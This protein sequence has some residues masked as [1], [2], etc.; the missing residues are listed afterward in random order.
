MNG[1]TFKGPGEKDVE[2]LGIPNSMHSGSSPKS[3]DSALVKTK[4]GGAGAAGKKTLEDRA[5][6]ANEQALKEDAPTAEMIRANT[7]GPE[8]TSVKPKATLKKV[9][10]TAAKTYF[11]SEAEVCAEFDIP[12][13][14]K[15]KTLVEF[16]LFRKEK[17]ENKPIKK[18]QSHADVSGRVTALLPVTASE[19]PKVT[20]VIKVKHC[21]GEWSSGQGTEREVSETAEIS[22][23]HTQVSGIH[24]SKGKSFIADIY[25]DALCE[26]KKI[27]LEWKKTHEK[28]QIVVYGHTE[29]DEQ[30]APLK[31]SRNRGLAA[32]SFIIGDVDRWADLAEKERWG[33]WEQQCMLRA[34]GFF[35]TK[36]TG[37]LG[38]ITRKAVQDFI[39][40]LNEARCKNINPML[41]L[42]EAYIRKEL[43]REYLNLKRSE[44]ELPSSAFRLVAG[45][46]YVGCCA[47][48]R[49]Q[50]RETLHEENRRVV[51]LIL[52]ESPNFPATFPC[53]SSTAGPCEQESQK[54]GDRAIKGFKCKFYDEMVREEKQAAAKDIAPHPQDEPPWITIA[55]KEIGETED[56]DKGENN[57]R[58][59]EYHQT[60]WLKADDDE[61]P[62]CASFVNWSI[63][64][65]G[66]KGKESARA[67][68]W[69]DWGRIVSKPIFGAVVVV[70]SAGKKKQ[71]HVGF[72]YGQKGNSLLILGGNQGGGLK[73]CVSEFS[74]ETVQGY[75]LPN[76]YKGA[77]IIAP[78]KNETYGKDNAETTR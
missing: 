5:R 76:E 65:S 62:W 43:Y 52:Q 72:V 12:S 45:Y 27:Y 60:T 47:F 30:E 6:S 46:P 55:R 24:F 9:G 75:R 31:I 61:T 7:Q 71:N 4:G 77:E 40:F 17:G 36:P 29:Q 54:P 18:V 32:F 39:T 1:H 14:I 28:A 51:F 19:E 15:D 49:Y 13:A 20:F 63:E 73:V 35:K 64:K 69:L 74:K 50:A 33:V 67:K 3:T 58:I 34:L 16:E 59:V 11:K 66:L 56:R 68:D 78:E 53:R 48:N 41:G 57:P 25:L 37:N 22:I 23:E 42:S 21:S 38:P 8:T 44:I 10:W 70:Q 26:V 2:K